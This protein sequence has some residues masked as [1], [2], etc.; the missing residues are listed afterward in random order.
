MRTV[1]LSLPDA[2]AVNLEENFAFYGYADVNELVIDVLQ[3]Q[4]KRDEGVV[5]RLLLDGLNSGAPI[6]ATPQ[7]WAEFRADTDALLAQDRQ[8]YKKAS[9]A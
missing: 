1:T 7:F 3:A 2:L 5:E 4:K 9:A 6:S 8:S